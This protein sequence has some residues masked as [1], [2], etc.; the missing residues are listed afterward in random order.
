MDLRKAYGSVPREALW[1]ILRIFGTLPVGD[2]CVEPVN[3]F[4]Y[5]GSLVASDGRVDTEVDKTITKVSEAF[6][7]LHVR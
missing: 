1:M 3:D 4:L 7:A 5:H 6:G 2:V